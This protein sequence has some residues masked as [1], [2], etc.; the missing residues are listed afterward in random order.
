M[1]PTPTTHPERPVLR[2]GAV[3]IVVGVL[4]GLGVGVFHGGSQPWDLQ[5]P[6]PLYAANRWWELVHLGQFVAELLLLVGFFAL[7]RSITA[8]SKGVSTA[9]A[10][11]GIIV[12]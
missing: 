5:A 4:L 8:I 10:Q 9:L 12:A 2:L 1:L 11:L 7:Y 6:L 3:S